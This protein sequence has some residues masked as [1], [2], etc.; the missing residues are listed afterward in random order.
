MPVSQHV[1]LSPATPWASP[2]KEPEGKQIKNTQKGSEAKA[3]A[4]GFSPATG[5][6]AHVARRWRVAD[7]GCRRPGEERRLMT[8]PLSRRPPLPTDGHLITGTTCRARRATQTPKAPT[9]PA[10]ARARRGPRVGRGRMAK[11]LLGAMAT[12]RKSDDREC[13]ER[14]TTQTRGRAGP[15][16]ESFTEGRLPEGALHSRLPA[17]VKWPNS[18]LQSHRTPDNHKSKA[19][20]TRSATCAPSPRCWR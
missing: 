6:P 11:A 7:G 1:G 4:A 17:L 15:H 9:R 19:F 12:R 16:P 18:E 3:D 14:P 5:G 13:G 20:A 10:R 8:H 2:P